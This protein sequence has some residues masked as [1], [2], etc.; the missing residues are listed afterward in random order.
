MGAIFP[1]PYVPPVYTDAQAVAAITALTSTAGDT[2]AR[3]VAGELTRVG[4]GPVAMGA[5]DVD[6]SAGFLQTKTVSG[7]VTLTA[8]NYTWAR[9][10]VTLELTNSG[11]VALPTF[12]GTT[13]VIGTWNSAT[14]AVNRITLVWAGGTTFRATIL[15]P[16]QPVGY[17]A[18]APSAGVATCDWALGNWFA[19]SGTPTSIVHTNY[20]PGWTVGFSATAATEPSYTPASPKTAG[21]W[22]TSGETHGTVT[23]TTGTSTVLTLY[24]PA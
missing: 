16:A 13:T 11:A 20:Q 19:I 4:I 21:T 5:S 14:G 6:F 1:R 12:P 22:Q 3:N 10:F 24:D 15:A 8:S 17:V 7:T 2:L 9:P 18:V 23:L